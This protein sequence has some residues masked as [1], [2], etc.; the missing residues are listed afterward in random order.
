[1]RQHLPMA[2]RHWE[3]KKKQ[4]PNDGSFII[5][6]FYSATI[7]LSSTGVLKVPAK[8]NYFRQLSVGIICSISTRPS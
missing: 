2:E 7:V 4:Q 6:F 5:F 1:M 3:L 8:L